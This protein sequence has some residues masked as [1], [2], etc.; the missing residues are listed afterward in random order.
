MSEEKKPS[1]L[2]RIELEV[3]MD[4]KNIPEQ[5]TWRATDA[6]PGNHEATAMMVALWDHHT[7]NGMSID[8]WTKQMTVPEMN[9]FFYQTLLSMSDSLKRSTQQQELSDDLMK[10]AKDFIAKANRIAS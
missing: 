2:S 6:D 4:E 3:R 1:R 5:I 10:F 7:K 9:I 8:L